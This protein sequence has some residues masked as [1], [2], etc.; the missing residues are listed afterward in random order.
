MIPKEKKEKSKTDLQNH[1]SVQPK[2]ISEEDH[3][4]LSFALHQ[5]LELVDFFT[6]LK[7]QGSLGLG[8]ILQSHWSNCSNCSLAFCNRNLRQTQLENFRTEMDQ[9]N[10]S[11]ANH[12]K[13]YKYTNDH[14]TTSPC[15]SF[16]RLPA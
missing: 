5:V 13:T 12:V 3:D 1:T 14:S 15:D 9:L 6:G 16:M 2:E 10:F 11:S 7:G 8:P 4:P